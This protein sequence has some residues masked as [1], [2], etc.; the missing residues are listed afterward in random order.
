MTLSSTTTTAFTESAFSYLERLQGSFNRT[1]LKAVE[2]LAKELREAWIEGRNVFICG[3]G[4]SAANAIH[5][6]NDFHYGIGACGPG[7]KLPGLR[8]EALPANTGIITC[9]ANDTWYENIYAHQLET[10]SRRGD[11]L[12]TLSGSGNSPNIVKVL[13]IANK[14]GSTLWQYWRS[15]GA[16][17][18]P[19]QKCNSLRN[20]RY[21]DRRRHST[22]NGHLC[23]QW[24]NAHK[25]KQIQSLSNG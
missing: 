3:N 24:L 8:I 16:E 1:N 17:Q 5:I 13:E 4:G 2:D 12:I 22:R 19:R 11:I 7:A 23:M 14:I 10:K 20:Q 15:Q 21:A 6:A 18:G 9:L 25:P